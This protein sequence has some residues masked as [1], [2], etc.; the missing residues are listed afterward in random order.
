MSII[1]EEDD[2]NSYDDLEEIA[3]EN[4]DEFSRN[5]NDLFISVGDN[6]DGNEFTVDY[7]IDEDD[8]DK[9]YEDNEKIDILKTMT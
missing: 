4:F 7:K 3:A 1:L 9:I 5:V 8:E 6:D 2:K